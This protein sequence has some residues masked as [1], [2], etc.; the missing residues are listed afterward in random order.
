MILATMAMLFTTLV[1]AGALYMLGRAEDGTLR[2]SLLGAWLALSLT[3]I[4]AVARLVA[5]HIGVH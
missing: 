4:I 1:W 5:A 2:L 3:V